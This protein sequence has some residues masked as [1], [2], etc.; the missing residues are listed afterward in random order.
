MAV[1]KLVD[2][3][4]LNSDLT[5]VANAIRAKS[6]G[7]SQLAFPAGFVSEIQSIVAGGGANERLLASG[8][9]TVTSSQSSITIA[10]GVASTAKTTKALVVG[11]LTSASSGFMKYFSVVYIDGPQTLKDAVGTNFPKCRY[12]NSAGTAGGIVNYQS[13]SASTTCCY[14]TADK[15]IVCRQWS[16]NYKIQPA[17]FSWYIWGEAAA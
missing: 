15:E 4:Q 13:G 5:S 11:D 2:S 8:T 6:G 12:Y 3:T 1:D 7:S 10:T 14:I 17:T 9:Y 16:A